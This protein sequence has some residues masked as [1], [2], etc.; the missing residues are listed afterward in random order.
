MLSRWNTLTFAFSDQ[1]LA[2]LFY[3]S[4]L[5]LTRDPYLVTSVTNMWVNAGRTC[6]TYQPGIPLSYAASLAWSSPTA[7]VCS[8]GWR[9]SLLH[10]ER[11]EVCF[12]GRK[13][14]VS[15]TCPGQ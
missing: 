14:S 4:G 15:A 7:G 13:G 1:R 5:G 6:F 10:V 3:I 12:P 2:T 9:P 8:S 11:N